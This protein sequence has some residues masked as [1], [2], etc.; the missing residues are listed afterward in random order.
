MLQHQ[1]RLFAAT[2]AAMLPIPLTAMAAPAWVDPG[3]APTIAVQA[4]MTC[5]LER[6][7]TQ[8]VRCDLL[9]GNGVPAPPWIPTR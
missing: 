6:V 9:T 3:D 2:A 7:D 4:Q 8:L 1:I 5:P